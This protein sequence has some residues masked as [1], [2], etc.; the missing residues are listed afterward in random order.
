MFAA[1]G[2]RA[3]WATVGLLFCETKEELM[4]SLPEQRPAYRNQALSNYT[5]LDEVGPDERRDPYYFAA[6]LVDQIS[7]TPGQEIGT[8]TLSHFYCLEHGQ[9]ADALRADLS[10]ACTL[11]SRRGISLKSIV[12]PRNQYSD[13]SLAVCKELGLTHFR[14]NSR[15]WVYLP[16]PT[17]GQT[18]IRRGLR[19][20]D[21]Y[22]GM[23]GSQVFDPA[24]R[25]G[26]VDVPASRF[27]R[28]C[29]GRL[30]PF[31]PL[32][33]STIQ[34]AMTVA[35]R[36]NKAFHLWW[37]PHNFGREIESNLQGLAK[38]LRHFRALQD[39]FGMQSFAMAD[40]R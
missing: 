15:G 38:I 5:Y 19:L 40:V 1:A 16:V 17:S 35:A 4:A 33:I 25:A 7:Q 26:L 3:T 37:H 36:Q 22:S 27:L 20:L 6:S 31:H 24:V 34:R 28:P 21:A 2:V 39:R 13:Q 23:F 14:G 30:A 8:H 29:A 10:A 11:A 18:R 9:T 12:F 32:H